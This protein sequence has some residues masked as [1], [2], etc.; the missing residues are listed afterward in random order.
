MTDRRH[1]LLGLAAWSLAPAR[2]GDGLDWR[3]LAP[4]LWCLPAATGDGGPA[5][6]GQVSNLL[7]AAAGGR[8]WLLGSG[9]SPAFGRRLAQSL[10]ERWAGRAL[11]VASPWPRP[12]LVLGVAGLPAAATHVAHAEVAA[13]MA[14]RCATCV[15][16]LRARLG[17]A[18][19]DLDPGDPVRLPTSLLTGER[20]ALG[21]WR[22]WRLQRAEDVT[23]TV[24]Q[25]VATGIVAAPGLLWDGGAPDGRDADIE[26]IAAA[27]AALARLPGL[28]RPTAWIGEQG[29]P[30]GAG[31]GA[32]AAVYWSALQAAVAAAL[33]RGDSGEAVPAT[34]PGV[35]PEVTAHPHHALNWQRAWRQS[36]ERWLQRSLR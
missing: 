29:G 7:L 4:G 27:S 2:A 16:R 13:Q 21:P 10:Q 34:L 3:A 18:A 1:A 20:G 22:W 33:E 5:D 17:N 26:R 30:Q 9:P 6:R 14:R 35:A 25:H 15:Q 24:W 23:V 12:E 31:A 32:A 11:T 36:E 19:T 8:L 28:A